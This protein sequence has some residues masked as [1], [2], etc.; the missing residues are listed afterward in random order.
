[1][2]VRIK[3]MEN[4]RRKQAKKEKRLN[5]FLFVSWGLIVTLLLGFMC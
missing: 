3:A 4:E 5:V 1:M 2:R